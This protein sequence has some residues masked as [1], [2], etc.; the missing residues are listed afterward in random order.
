MSASVVFEGLDELRAQL[1]SLPADL[2]AEAS[3]IVIGKATEAFQEIHDGYPDVSGTLRD[4]LTLLTNPSAVGAG[5][6][7]KNTD[8]IAWIFE[9]GSQVRLFDGASR[10]AM[11][12]GHVFIPIAQRKRREMY[13][14]L[15]A[16]LVEHGLTVSGDAE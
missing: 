16:M 10:G 15:Q 13:E 4:R 5:A 7:L 14:Q 12:P 11:P 1:R 2:A 9:N 8:P 3:G 6:I